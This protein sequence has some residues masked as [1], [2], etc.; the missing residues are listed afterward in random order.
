M[1][2]GV[3][4]DLDGTLL[5]TLEDLADATNYALE[6]HGYPTRTID[7]VRQF[8]GNGAARLIR[9]AVPEGADPQPVLETFGV[10][11]ESHCQIKTRAYDGILEALAE[12]GRKYP[13]AIVSNK[14]DFAVKPLCRQYFGDIYGLGESPDCPRK[15]APDMVFKAMRAIGVDACVYVGDSDVDVLTAKNA[16]MPCLSVLWGFRDRECIAAAG[17]TYFCQDPKQLLAALDSIV[18]DM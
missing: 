2:I 7:E 5:N 4:W 6:R 17:G 13:M 14:P 15:P 8:V 12:V 9:L 3:L 16:G 1:K 18:R 10:Y 11:Y